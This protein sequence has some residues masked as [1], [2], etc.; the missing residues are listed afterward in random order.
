MH[1]FQT[2]V[3]RDADHATGLG[4]MT[5]VLSLHYEQPGKEPKSAVARFMRY[6][7]S[8]EQP[9][10]RET[11]VGPTWT[12]L[13]YDWLAKPG[14]VHLR[15]RE[16]APGATMPT[17]EE[18]EMVFGRALEVGVGSTTGTPPDEATIVIK[19]SE[20]YPLPFSQEVTDRL[21]VRCARGKCQY[22]LTAYPA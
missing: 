9:Y 14:L 15:N 18:L 22:T 17:P 3:I 12:K 16:G 19:P 13:T 7:D 1:P 4:R 6:V 11:R 21:W 2:P 8:D 5:M 20:G 10:Y